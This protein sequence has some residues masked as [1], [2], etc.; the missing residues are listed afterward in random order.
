MLVYDMQTSGLTVLDPDE[1]ILFYV[2]GDL[3]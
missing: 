1:E 2:A 3:W